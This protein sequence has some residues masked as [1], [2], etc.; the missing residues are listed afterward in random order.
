MLS[1]KFFFFRQLCLESPLRGIQ[2]ATIQRQHSQ[3]VFAVRG[4][5]LPVVVARI[6]LHQRQRGIAIPGQPLV[7]VR[8][9]ALLPIDVADPVFR[10]RA[11]EQEAAIIGVPRGQFR[12]ALIGALE[13]IRRRCV[14]G[15]VQP[16]L[17]Y[18]HQ[19]A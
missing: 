16:D 4:L 15:L 18:L 8:Q 1:G 7:G 2:V 19:R 11:I 10:L 6:D 9:L 5:E 17:A 14:P 12:A 13:G 3:I